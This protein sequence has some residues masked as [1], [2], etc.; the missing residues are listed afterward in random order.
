MMKHVKDPVV[1]AT[2]NG[3]LTNARRLHSPNNFQPT[4]VWKAPQRKALRVPVVESR[5][6]LSPMEAW[7]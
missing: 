1:A 4:L 3:A 6:R 2:T 5:L 7:K